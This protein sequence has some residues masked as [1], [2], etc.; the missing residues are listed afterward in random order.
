MAEV[1]FAE[2]KRRLREAAGVM[3]DSLAVSATVRVQRV[4]VTE[5][6]SSW[7]EYFE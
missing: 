4:R 5:T 3:G 2:A 1:I 7:A 6:S